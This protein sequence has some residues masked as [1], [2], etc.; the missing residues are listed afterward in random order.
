MGGIRS[1]VAATALMLCICAC[2]KKA[3]G[4]VCFNSDECEEGLKCVGEQG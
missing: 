4:K 3:E 2:G 1:V